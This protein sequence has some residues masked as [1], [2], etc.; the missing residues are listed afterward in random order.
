MTA[1]LSPEGLGHRYGRRTWGLRD[2]TVT[3]PAGRVVALVGPN[4][5][6]KTT[7][8]HM[9]AGLLRPTEGRVEIAGAPPGARLSRVGFIAQDAPLWPRM[10]V[11]TVLEAS[12]ARERLR[13]GGR[14]LPECQGAASRGAAAR[15]GWC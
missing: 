3:I 7:L 2:C 10:R 4:G 13:L 12:V 6:G 1:V 9:A 15:S 5:S 8:M 14:C 11:G